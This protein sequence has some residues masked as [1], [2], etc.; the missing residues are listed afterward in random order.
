MPIPKE[1]KRMIPPI[2]SLTLFMEGVDTTIINTAIPAMSRSFEVNPIHLKIALISYLMSLAIFI[3]IS[4]WL[5]DKFGTKRVYLSAVIIFTLSSVWCGFA[6][7]LLMLVFARIAQGFGGSLMMPIGR[8][9]IVRSF[10]RNEF[11]TTMTRVVILASF[12]PML[13]PLL[14]GIITE[15]FS[16]PWIFWVNIPFGIIAL[17]LGL[18]R[19]PEMPPRPYSLIA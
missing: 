12:G 1:Y 14:G 2:I 18:Y 13:G 19:L 17:L 11:I 6:H 7:S 3:P 4:G 10:N 16:W 5:A 15:Q 8:L 9:I